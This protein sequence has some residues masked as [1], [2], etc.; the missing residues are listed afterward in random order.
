MPYPEGIEPKIFTLDRKLYHF[1]L[2]AFLL[3]FAAEASAQDLH[4]SQRFSSPLNLSPALAGIYGGEHRIVGNARNQWQNRNELVGYKSVSAS[5]DTKLNYE[6]GVT[7]FWGVGAQFNYDQAGDSRLSLAQLG[8]NVS[9][10]QRLSERHLLTA[11][12]QL[13]GGQRRFENADLLF[14]DQYDASKPQDDLDP[15]AE[16]FSPEETQFYP[17]LSAG[18]NWRYQV[19][20]SRTFINIGGGLYHLNTPDVSFFDGS[21]VSLDQ[22][23]S[24]YVLGTYMLADRFDV[25]ANYTHQWQGPHNEPLAGLRGKFYLMNPLVRTLALQL[26]AHW[27]FRDALIPVVKANIDN[28]ELGFSYDLNTSDFD[29]ATDTNGGPELSVIYTFQKIRPEIC[30]LCPEYL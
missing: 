9:Y 14:N 1:V 25:I 21:D 2:A 7:G 6:P 28:W 12:A 26:G 24:A 29:I 11:G 23:A 22:R 18:I 3:A 15:S 13:A 4:Y 16:G 8:L 10:T 30:L 27:R 19:R 20:E 17:S 5:Y